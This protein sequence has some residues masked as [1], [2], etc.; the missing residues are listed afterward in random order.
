MKTLLVGACSPETTFTLVDP[1]APSEAEFEHT[2]VRALA[3]A[4]PQY[5]CVVFG[6]SFYHED[7]GLRRPD[8]ALVARDLS[9]WFVIEVELTSHSLEHHVL[10]QIRAFAYGTPRSD[11]AG[12]L[13][14]GLEISTSQAETLVSL[15]PRTVA[16]VANRRDD[17]W[18]HSLRGLNAQLLVVSVFRT[19]QGT[20]A[21]QVDGDLRVVSESLGFGVYS[22]TDR[23]FRFTSG[24]RLPLGEVQL[25]G[26]DG[27][28]TTWRVAEA[29]GHVWV[30]KAAGRPDIEHGAFGQV[31]KTFDGRLLLKV[32]GRRS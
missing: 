5:R 29:S 22:A 27:A 23:S 18:L 12:S 6:G 1:D 25:V 21:T 15:V 7:A 11:C 17:E 2:V 10:P 20:T 26:D 13:A 4:Y 30:T 32:P 16:V 14:R 3:C 8:L 9:H 28:A 31:V 24:I 19:E